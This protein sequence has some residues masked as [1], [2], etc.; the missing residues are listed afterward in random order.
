MAATTEIDRL[1]VTLMGNATHLMNTVRQSQTQVAASAKSMGQSAAAA[2]RQVTRMLDATAMRLQN[3]ARTARMTGIILSASVTAPLVLMARSAVREFSEFDK[4][5]TNSLSIA[6]GVTPRIRKQMEDTAMAMAEQGVF[7]AKELADAY[8]QL[9]SAGFKLQDSL[10]SI[11]VVSDFATAGQMNLEQATKMLAKATFAMGMEGKTAAETEKNMTRVADV[12]AQGANMVTANIQEMTEALVNAAAPAAKLLGMSIEETVAALQVYIQKGS[13][14]ATASEHLAIGLRLTQQAF[15]KHSKD[16][17]AMGKTMG[18]NMNIYDRV[19]GKIKPFADIVDVLSQALTNLSDRERTIALEALGFEALQQRAILP[20]IGMAAQMRKNEQELKKTGEAHRIAQVQL[21]SFD[22]ATKRL[23]HTWQNVKIEL[24][25]EVAPAL[26]QLADLLKGALAY[27]KSLDDQTKWAAIRFAALVAA[28]GPLIVVFTT[29]FNPVGLVLAGVTAFT[30]L[31]G[32][33]NG[34]VVGAFQSVASVIDRVFLGVIGHTIEMIKSLRGELESVLAV[35]RIQTERRD[36]LA[37]QYGEPVAKLYDKQAKAQEEVDKKREAFRQAEQ[38]GRG[39]AGAAAANSMSLFANMQMFLGDEKIRAFRQD[40]LKQE[41]KRILKEHPSPEVSR[42]R[43]ELESAQRAAMAATQAF[44]KKR[45]RAMSGSLMDKVLPVPSIIASQIKDLPIVDKIK[46]KLTD[47]WESSTSAA[48]AYGEQATKNTERFTDMQ[49]DVAEL[50]EKFQQQIAIQ[51]EEAKH[52]YK[53]TESQRALFN[54]RWEMQ[55]AFAR[56]EAEL[57][58]QVELHTTRVSNNQTGALVDLA[59]A[60]KQ[61]ED[62][63]AAYKAATEGRFKEAEALAKQTEQL[64]EQKDLHE[65]VKQ[66]NPQQKL[67]EELE[68]ANKAQKAGLLDAKA[69]QDIIKKIRKETQEHNG[70]LKKMHD[71]AKTSGYIQAERF[72][73]VNMQ[74]QIAQHNAELAAHGVPAGMSSPMKRGPSAHLQALKQIEK[75]N[76]DQR[77]MHRHTDAVRHILKTSQSSAEE[78]ERLA[79]EQGIHERVLKHNQERF[80]RTTRQAAHGP[81]RMQILLA[82]DREEAIQ[83]HAKIVGRL[84]DPTKIAK[85]QARHEAQLAAFD[86]R[87]ARVVASRPVDAKLQQYGK[88]ETKL[89]DRIAKATEATA[90]KKDVKVEPANL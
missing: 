32:Y 48:K 5:M 44:E 80:D 4:A 7:S 50:T 11:Q 17:I 88:A 79:K 27:W 73:R 42:A 47:L 46:S 1:V 56:G 9:I 28:A 49:R 75:H 55:Q 58:Q 30:A 74:L 15:A 34:S 86:K 25:R 8:Y 60:K 61:L 54:K 77:A 82:R 89:L 31:V 35:K 70:E 53:L 36:L 45:R 21:T 24:G 52:N 20:L 83:R 90:K 2:E 51:E 10:K 62:Y 81:G 87:G 85:E 57:Q 23:L 78:R 66:N 43:G 76:A 63:R 3:L 12:L 41:T 37:K 68:K 69:Y 65:W 13:S 71:F 14:M 33:M 72:N 38:R 19:T 59:R 6:Q 84:Q 39:A 40:Q 64:R 22:A 26:M 67:R 16:W 29:L 18:I